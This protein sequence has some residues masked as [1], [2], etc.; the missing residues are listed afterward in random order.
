MA[1]HVATYLD[2]Q[3]RRWSQAKK[4]IIAGDFVNAVQRHAEL[5]G[6][7]S[8]PVLRQVAVAILQPEQG[9]DN[10]DSA[11]A[12]ARFRAGRVCQSRKPPI[13]ALLL[14]PRRVPGGRFFILRELPPP[15]IT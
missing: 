13:N 8:Q 11:A 3:A 5:A 1:A 4:R 7:F 12:A 9:W 10:H 15:R 14:L 6:E 2:L